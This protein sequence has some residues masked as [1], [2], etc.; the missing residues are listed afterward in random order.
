MAAPKHYEQN[1]AV[2]ASELWS[3]AADGMAS[4]MPQF[5]LPQ[6]RVGQI[7]PAD[8]KGATPS[9]HRLDM[10]NVLFF[11]AFLLSYCLCICM[12][13]L[14]LA[15]IF[16]EHHRFLNVAVKSHDPN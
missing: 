7:W 5:L 14:R 6:S 12:S 11:W 16:C 9:D 3:S 13:H 15:A 2:I 4:P 8:C 1:C 10:C